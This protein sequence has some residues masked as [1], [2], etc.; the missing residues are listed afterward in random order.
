MSVDSGFLIPGFRISHPWL[1]DSL[2]DWIPDFKMLFWIL[3]SISW[4][5]DSKA[6]NSRLHR[7][8]LPGFQIPYYLTWGH[9][10][11]LTGRKMHTRNFK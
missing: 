3:D 7:P 10:M 2:S 9:M 6:V 4:I 11:L 8:N 5:P 1:P